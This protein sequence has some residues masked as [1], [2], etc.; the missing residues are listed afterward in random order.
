MAVSAQEIRRGSCDTSSYSMVVA[1]TSQQIRIRR[2]AAGGWYARRSM[3]RTRRQ[4]RFASG[5]ALSSRGAVALLRSFTKG[6]NEPL[7]VGSSRIHHLVVVSASFGKVI[8]PR[9][10]QLSDR[11]SHTGMTAIVF[12]RSRRVVLVLCCLFFRYDKIR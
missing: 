1:A 8:A 11:S 4:P 10:R 2:L 5:D 9:R 6:R 12:H 3:C 7:V